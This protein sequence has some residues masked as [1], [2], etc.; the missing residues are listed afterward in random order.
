[1]YSI[2]E[3]SFGLVS[4]L[5]YIYYERKYFTKIIGVLERYG[6]YRKAKEIKNC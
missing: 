6:V 2:L 4:G 1:M 5:P 3:L